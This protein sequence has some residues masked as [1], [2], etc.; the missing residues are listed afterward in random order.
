MLSVISSKLTVKRVPI[1]ESHTKTSA[2][3]FFSASRLEEDAATQQL[4]ERQQLLWKIS[5]HPDAEH[6]P[7]LGV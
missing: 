5:T 6:R 4:G 7:K 1:L 3:S 2:I